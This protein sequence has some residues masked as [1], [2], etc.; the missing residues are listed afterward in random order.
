MIVYGTAGVLESFRAMDSTCGPPCETLRLHR[1]RPTAPRKGKNRWVPPSPHQFQSTVSTPQHMEAGLRSSHQQVQ[2]ASFLKGQPRS[3]TIPG[4]Q[5][6]CSA[7]PIRRMSH[8]DV[9]G[10]AVTAA[11]PQ[12][13]RVAGV[14]L[15]PSET[16]KPGYILGAPQ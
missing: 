14:V 15:R 2:P 11:S 8:Q 5:V 16:L 12:L 3:Y 1:F 6:M 9:R 13:A 4:Q 10:L 7:H